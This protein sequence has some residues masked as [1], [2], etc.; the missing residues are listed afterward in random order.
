MDNWSSIKA[1]AILE[2]DF[3]LKELLKDIDD[4]FLLPR[5]EKWRKI[6]DLFIANR[7][8]LKAQIALVIKEIKEERA[9]SGAWNK[10]A[11]SA[12]K[13]M[14][15]GLKMPQ[16]YWEILSTCDPEFAERMSGSGGTT[17]EQKK[18]YKELCQAF[19][20]FQVPLVM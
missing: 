13:T 5:K 10:Y 16:F 12:D 3:R 20:E 14:R 4:A 11:E 2:N 1:N 9:T 8:D 15:L 7:P 6:I 17:A 18:M 19:P